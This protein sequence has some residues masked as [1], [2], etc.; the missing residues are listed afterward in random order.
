M[1]LL[2]SVHIE[3]LSFNENKD[4]YFAYSYKVTHRN[5]KITSIHVNS[6]ACTIVRNSR[7]AVTTI[8]ALWHENYIFQRCVP[9]AV[10]ILKYQMSKNDHTSSLT[11]VFN[12]LIMFTT[13]L[14]FKFHHSSHKNKMTSKYKFST[15]WF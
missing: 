8:L 4:V 5:W 12:S 13:I 2:I 10:C 15:Q 9:L 14:L 3:L 7:T 6:V 11:S 1:Y